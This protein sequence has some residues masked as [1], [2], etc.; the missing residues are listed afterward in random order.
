MGE[1]ALYFLDAVVVRAC[2]GVAEW[3]ERHGSRNAVFCRRG[4]SV[5]D[6]LIFSGALVLIDE[7]EAEFLAAHVASGEFLLG[8]E[9]GSGGLGVGVVEERGVRVV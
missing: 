3:V 9:R 8:L 7:L 6:N 4:R 2:L 5:V 1:I